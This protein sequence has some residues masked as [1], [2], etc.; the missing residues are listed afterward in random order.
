MQVLV[1]CDDPICC[2]NEL[3][4]RVEGVIAG[5]LER[6]GEHVSRV[7]VGLRDLNS[8]RPGDRDKVCSLEARL[9][10]SAP[11]SVEY[12]APTL[13]EAIHVA[14]GQLERLVG[15]HLRELSR[16]LSATR[17]AGHSATPR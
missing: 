11:V 6:F 8:E 17:A 13:A 3:I 5:T 9:T 14:A 15:Q 1:Q 2:E 12:K 16:T 4:R 7:E 10:G